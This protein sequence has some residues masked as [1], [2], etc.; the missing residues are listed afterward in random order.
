MSL[1]K[2]RLLFESKYDN[3]MVSEAIEIARASKE[4]GRVIFMM[5]NLALFSSMY[6]QFEAYFLRVFLLDV[7]ENYDFA[8]SKP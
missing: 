4:I 7:D 6:I 5:S 2:L 1:K 3:E 8:V